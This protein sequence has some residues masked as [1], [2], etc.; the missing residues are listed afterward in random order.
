MTA[1]K[2]VFATVPL[3]SKTP[4]PVDAILQESAG[5]AA[6]NGILTIM[7]PEPETKLEP[8]KTTKVV[9]IRKPKT[10]R[11]QQSLTRRLTVVLPTY[12][13]DSVFKKA[14]EEKATVRFLIAQALSGAGYHVEPEDLMEDLRRE[15]E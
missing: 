3:K 4:P 1:S 12:L 2:P 8:A 14:F 7:P 6:E 11:K 9:P 5:L 10:A 13:V 15:Y